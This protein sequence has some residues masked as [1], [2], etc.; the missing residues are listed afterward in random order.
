MKLSQSLIAFALFVGLAVIGRWVPHPPNFSPLL[1]I[2]LVG[3]AGAASLGVA[4]A[5]PLTALLLSDWLIGFHDQM[6][7]VYLSLALV[8]FV[9]R[10][11]DLNS[12]GIKGGVWRFLRQ[13]TLASLIFFFV[14]NLAVWYFSPLYPQTGSGLWTCYV[15]ALPF[16]HNTLLSTLVYGSILLGAFKWMGSME[17]RKAELNQ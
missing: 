14:T 12:V 8:V 17:W 5:L 3:A 2:A 9:G 13:A 10:R 16:F 6:P 4:L 15:A 7:A 1:A 11:L